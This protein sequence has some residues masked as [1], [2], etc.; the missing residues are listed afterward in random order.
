MNKEGG[1]PDPEDPGKKP[2]GAEKPSPEAPSVARTAG[3]GRS[4]ERPVPGQSPADAAPVDAGPDTDS[5]RDDLAKFNDEVRRRMRRQTRRSFLVGGMA[6]LAGVGGWRW[7]TSRREEDGIPWPFR[8]TLEINEQLARDFFRRDRLAPTFSPELARVDR[9]N[10]DAGMD[11][12]IDIDAWKL[13]VEGLA[14]TNEPFMLTLDA[15][16]KLPRIEMTTELKCIEGWSVV[17]R[18]AGARFADFMAAYPPA[19]LSG[20][21]LDLLGNTRDL[22]PYVGMQTPDGGYYVGLEMESMLH[23]QTLLC[24]EMNGAPLTDEHGAPLRLVIPV[25]YGVK[26]IKR[27]GKIS[28]TRRRPADYWAERGYDWYIGL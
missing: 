15:I 4:E 28:Y 2:T 8:R 27:I 12:D 11:D 16:K 17:V 22:P 14:A 25:K 3:D 13:A 26:N 23:P 1:T 19:T 10:G 24:Y 5:A 7:L 6:A 18:W 9:V 21:P 20:D